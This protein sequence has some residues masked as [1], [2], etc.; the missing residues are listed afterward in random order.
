MRLVFLRRTYFAYAHR[1]NRA[2]LYWRDFYFA[3]LTISE[4]GSPQAMGICRRISG[5]RRERW[6]LDRQALRTLN[7]YGR[8][9]QRRLGCSFLDL[10]LRL[11][12]GFLLTASMRASIQS[13]FQ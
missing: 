1:R 12:R 5:I 13:L 6:G 10:H 8:S 9:G 3:E 7:R 11:L 4:A 2:D